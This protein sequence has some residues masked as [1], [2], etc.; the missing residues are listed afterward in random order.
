[1]E[2]H[3]RGSRAGIAL[4]SHDRALLA[5]SVS[6]IL[7][8]DEFTRRGTEFRGGWE[9]YL[10]ERERAHRHAV[11]AYANYEQERT[12]LTDTARTQ[13]QWAASGAQRAADPRRQLD[14]DKFIK[15]YRVAGAQNTGAGAARTERAIA[16]LDR[17]APDQVREPWR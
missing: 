1:L 2:A 8:L 12:R 11:E 14:P 5:G 9:A 16:R 13:R 3:L 6:S 4:V 10:A 15:A 17:D 7:E